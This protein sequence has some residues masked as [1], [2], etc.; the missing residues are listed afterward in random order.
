MLARYALAW[1]STAASLAMAA[2]PAALSAQPAYP[3]APIKAIAMFPAG[4]GAD[5]RIR[6]YAKK[7]SELAGQPVVVENKPGAFGNIATEAVARS[8]PDGYTIYIAPTSSTHAAA[9]HLFKKLPFDPIADF[10]QITTLARASFVLCVAG[11][12]PFNTVPDLV[13]HLKERGD[14]ASY[15][16]IAVPSLVAGELFKTAFGLKAIEIKYKDQAPFIAE[17]VAGHISFFYIDLGTI[18]S[19]LKAGTVRPLAMASAKR[20]STVPNIPGAAEVGI[21]NMNLEIWWSVSV[22]AKTPQPIRDQLEKWFNAIVAD[23]ET[24][25]FNVMSGSEKLPGNAALARRMLVEH[26]K[27]WAEYARIAKIEPQ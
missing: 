19:H 1:I 6:F 23:P 2:L 27:V 14:A 21:P 8:R 20:L 11:N 16:T 24:E 3:S 25:A 13:K 22:P 7:L 4:T 26:T 9:P 10:E 17:L 12:S 18:A 15:G 5:I